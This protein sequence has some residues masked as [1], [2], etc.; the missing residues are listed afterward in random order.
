MTASQLLPKD[1]MN[2]QQVTLFGNWKDQYHIPNKTFPISQANSVYISFSPKP[3]ELPP[4]LDPAELFD[5]SDLSKTLE[6]LEQPKP[7]PINFTLHT[8]TSYEK[9]EIDT[10]QLPFIV[11]RK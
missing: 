3:S 9:K 8:K 7:T 4:F 1:L 10:E 2:T 6:P 11:D 5:I